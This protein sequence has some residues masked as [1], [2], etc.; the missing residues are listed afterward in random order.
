MSAASTYQQL[1]LPLA[2]VG[3]AALPTRNGVDK[4]PAV[5]FA[6]L[7]SATEHEAVA[8][9]RSWSSPHQAALLLL[10]RLAGTS[11][12]ADLDVVDVDDLSCLDWALATFGNTPLR[13]TS[14]RSGGGV[15]LYYRRDPSRPRESRGSRTKVAGRGVDHKSWHGLV[16]CPGSVHRT[17]AIYQA[18]WQGR[19]IS[20]AEFA[21]VLGRAS[22][23]L[24]ILDAEILDR[25]RADPGLPSP[26]WAGQGVVGAALAL[27]GP[28]SSTFGLGANLAPQ[29]RPGGAGRLPKATAEA[30]QVIAHGSW[31]GQTIEAA[32][33]MLGAGQAQVCCPHAADGLPH[34]TDVNGGTSAIL[35]AEGGKPAFLVC[36]ACSITYTYG[37]RP[38]SS[39][40]GQELTDEQFDA[41]CPPL[42]P[43]E[44][45]ASRVLAAG[46]AKEAFDLIITNRL[47]SPAGIRMAEAAIEA[48]RDALV[49]EERSAALSV[50][51]SRLQSKREA[52]EALD[53]ELVLGAQRTL[54]EAKHI[55]GEVRNTLRAQ[56]LP[57]PDGDAPCGFHLGTQNGVTGS[58]AAYRRLCGSLSC[59]TCGPVVVARKI[60][61]VL[62]MPL[63]NAG[64]V[65]CGAPLGDRPLYEYECSIEE[66]QSLLR[67]LRRALC[68]KSSIESVPIEDFGHKGEGIHG[69]AVFNQ[70]NR[71]VVL[72]S[73]IR[74]PEPRRVMKKAPLIVFRGVLSSAEQ[75]RAR[76]VELGLSAYQVEAADAWGVPCPPV[77]VGR[78]STSQNLHTDPAEVVRIASASPWISA[79]RVEPAKVKIGLEARKIAHSVK[80]EAGRVELVSTND[81]VDPRVA[82]EVFEEA[83]LQK[84]QAPSSSACPPQQQA[85]L[86]G[87]LD[88]LLIEKTPQ[89]Q[90]AEDEDAED[91]VEVEAARKS[92]ELLPNKPA[93]LLPIPGVA[94][95]IRRAP[96]NIR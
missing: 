34:K 70:P 72:I 50:Y 22:S 26:A 43:R 12:G 78:I 36:F 59:P 27:Q 82:S 30:G 17:G 93:P 1:A 64:G 65:V 95:A 14:G 85:V 66:L 62:N 5:P 87:L 79:G 4:T 58:V 47:N 19:E 74:R 29:T 39:A 44:Q 61:A 13:V 11:D 38:Q 53:P 77:V 69:Y 46:R 55:V 52:A 75:R 54:R 86:D 31:A 67:R 10:D 15:H 92:H 88:D 60:S 81:Y 18:Y 42:S 96:W 28:P 40:S 76:L 25:V 24:P 91:E 33:R 32:A 56:G 3:F 45:E 68:P 89:P 21:Q 37:S 2:N 94:T 51:E 35:H 84:R 7:T 63:V 90:E 83:G 71:R 48:L 8:E 57:S 73:S 16:V 23:T 80:I 41:I 6:T 9:M 49:V 20:P